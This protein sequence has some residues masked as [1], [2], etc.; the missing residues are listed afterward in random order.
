M[1]LLKILVAI[2]M[3][4]GAAV[5]HKPITVQPTGGVSKLTLRSNARNPHDCPYLTTS[6]VVEGVTPCGGQGETLEVRITDCTTLPCQIQLGSTYDLEVDFVPAKTHTTLDV[7]ISVIH[8]GQEN[9]IGHET[10]P[11]EV[12]S[13]ESFTMA[14]P[15]A[16]SGDLATGTLIALKVQIAGDRVT[17]VCGLL[18]AQFSDASSKLVAQ[19]AEV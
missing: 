14:Y 6:I 7:T 15:W 3:G 9:Q 11:A 17:E 16:A 12:N 2:V 5:A 1:H 4:V 10:I 18:T 13:G 8:G 19:G